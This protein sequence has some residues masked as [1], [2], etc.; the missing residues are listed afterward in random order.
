MTYRHLRISSCVQDVQNN[1]DQSVTNCDKNGL[2]ELIKK[3]QTELEEERE[4][5]KKLTLELRTLKSKQVSLQ[6]Q[7]EAE[8]E[9]ITNKLMKHLSDLKKEKELLARQVEQEEEY[10]TNTLQKKLEQLKK[11]KVDLENQLEQEEEYIVNKLRKELTLLQQEKAHLEKKLEEEKETRERYKMMQKEMEEVRTQIENYKRNVETFKQQ[12]EKLQDELK[13]L[14]TDNFVLQQKILKEH[15]KL[16]AINSERALLQSSVEIDLER[17]YNQAYRREG[18][19]ASATKANVTRLQRHRSMSAPRRPSSLLL[20]KVSSPKEGTTTPPFTL[21]TVPSP[22]LTSSSALPTSP[23]S[24]SSSL[25]AP[26]TLSTMSDPV[27]PLLPLKAVSSPL[28]VATTIGS[29]RGVVSSPRTVGSSKRSRSSSGMSN[30]PTKSPHF[31]TVKVLKKGWMRHRQNSETDAV[32]FFWVLFEN[33]KL[34]A[35]SNADYE[36]VSEH[37]QRILNMDTMKNVVISK[38]NTIIVTLATNPPEVHHFKCES[39]AEA[40]QWLDLMRNLL[41]YTDTP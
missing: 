8:E 31:S 14:Q 13:R 30:S 37:P 34:E 3:L 23:T 39:T 9:N 25:R 26:T 24:T 22:T 36:L 2:I 32:P 17:Q 11:E 19:K 15:E 5:N 28:T 10:L 6:V 4:K 35:Y 38:D 21:T 12:N 40:Q 16:S 27:V 33:G 18:M 20:P 7:I 29:P 41:P 1:M